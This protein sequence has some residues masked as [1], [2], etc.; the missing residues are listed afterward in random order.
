MLFAAALQF[1]GGLSCGFRRL[2]A[3]NEVG[4]WGLAELTK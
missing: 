4:G 1:L 2:M 3:M